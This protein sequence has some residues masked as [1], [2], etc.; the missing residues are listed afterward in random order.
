[1]AWRLNGEFT[2]DPSLL[3][4]VEVRFTALG[5]GETR[6]DLEHRGLEVFGASSQADQVRNNMDQGWSVILEAFKA[7]ANI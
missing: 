7:V 5:D 4:E 6:V 1:M 3:T 2:F